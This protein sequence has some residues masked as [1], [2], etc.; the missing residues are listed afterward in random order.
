MADEDKF[1]TIEDGVV[2]GC[3]ESATEIAIP[4]G[5]T[6][7][8]GAAFSYCESLA[9][10]TIPNSV[11]EIGEAAFYDCRSLADIRFGGTKAQWKAIEKGEDWDS[12]VPASTVHCT[13]GETQLVDLWACGPLTIKGGVVTGC[14]ESATEIAIPEGVTEIG[15]GAFSECESLVGITIPNSVTE[16]GEGAFSGCT[17]LASITI[18]DSVTE[19]GEGAF[20]GCTSLGSITIPDSVTEIGDWAFSECE[21]LVGITIPNGVTEIG[22]NAF[23][24]CASLA[25][26]TIP[27]GVTEIGRDAFHDCRSLASITIPNSMTEIGALAFAG[28]KS[29]ADIRFGGT[30]SQWKAVEKGKY[31]DRNIP[32]SMVHCTDGETQQTDPV[33]SGTANR[34]G[35]LTIEGGVV[36][37]CDES[38]TE[39]AIPEGVTEIG[40]WAFEDCQSLADIRF[41]GTKAQ[42]KAVKKGDGW[43]SGIPA[44]TVLCTDG[45]TQLTL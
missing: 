30:E 21:S 44:S 20:C 29:L 11:T 8:D 15:E 27:N 7:I 17:S 40:A 10:I 36:T 39:I 4:E 33:V 9:S 16:I 38:A 22:E 28:C 24:W 6:E 12:G 34:S 3:D 19:I 41:G 32:A 2:T 35:P 43:D 23:S 45:E 37:G 18:P 1:L 14:D 13:D 25:S 31:W 26:I 42:W 5:V